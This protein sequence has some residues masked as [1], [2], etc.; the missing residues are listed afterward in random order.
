MNIPGVVWQGNVSEVY[1]GRLIARQV[2]RERGLRQRGRPERC[3]AARRRRIYGIAAHEGRRAIAVK[4][5]EEARAVDRTIATLA[6]IGQERP[7]DANRAATELE[8]R[9]ADVLQA[10]GEVLTASAHLAQLLDLPPSPRLQATDGWVVPAPIVPDPIPLPQLIAIALTQ[11]PELA[12]RRTAIQEALLALDAAKILPFSPTL[13]VGYSAGTFG[14]GSNIASDGTAGTQARFDNFA[15]ANRSRRRGLLD[16]APISASATW[17]RFGWP[18]ATS[19]PTTC[20]KSKSSTECAA[21]VAT[22]YART[23][24]RYAQIE[25]GEHGSDRRQGLSGRFGANQEPGGFAH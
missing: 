17:R 6:V 11:R 10:E 23:H 19:A 2:V 22:A 16:G 1:Y 7:A 12:E 25:T 21:E 4:T 15:P 18:K 8:Q 13:I 20:A 24:A 14:G 9:N 5:R 3:A